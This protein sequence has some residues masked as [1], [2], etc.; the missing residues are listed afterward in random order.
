MTPTE[1]N[2]RYASLNAP[3]HCRAYGN[4]VSPE[5]LAKSN[6]DKNKFFNDPA[7]RE[8]LNAGT[9]T[10][11]STLLRDAVLN[12]VVEDFSRRLLP[13]SAFSTVFQRVPLQG[14]NKVQ[15]PFYDLDTGASTSFLASAG[16]VAGDT[17]TDNREIQIGKRAPADV[18]DGTK[19]YDRKYQGVSLT[20]EELAR[21]PFLN[22]VQLVRLKVDKLA[23]DILAHV[24][25]IIT[26]ANYGAAEITKVA[27]LFNSDDLASLKL[28]CKLWQDDTRSLVLDSAYDAALL[29]DPAFKSAH[30]AGTDR[31]IREGK[32]M[33]RV[34]GFD[35][36]EVPTIPANGENLVGFAA[37]KAAILFAQAP[38]PPGPEVRNAGTVYAVATDS[39]TGVSLEYRSFGDNQADSS[40]HIIEA[41]YGFAKGNGNALKRIVSA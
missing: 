20:S 16:Y 14:T 32:L 31:A 29:R 9:N 28:A 6:A 27:A 10:I 39:K 37:H 41:S 25:G 22:V 33:P 34:Y 12:A 13:L 21:Q 23:S 5:D 26:A 24:L 7:T 40:R 18:A 3:W 30:S 36:H 4:P 17:A 8:V 15:V 1:L 38:V 11:D 19:Q 35:Y 2:L